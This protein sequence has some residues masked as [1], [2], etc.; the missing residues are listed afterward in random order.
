MSDRIVPRRTEQVAVD[1]LQGLLAQVRDLLAEGGPM[2][3]QA[4]AMVFDEMASVCTVAKEALD[5]RAAQQEVAHV[6]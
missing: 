6:R 4:A 1:T 5:R 3:G 2:A